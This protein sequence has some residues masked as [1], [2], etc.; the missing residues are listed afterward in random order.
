MTYYIVK[1]EHT[2]LERWEQFLAPHI[3]YLAGL[4]KQEKL[5]MSGPIKNNDE[6]VNEA[7]LVFSVDD[8]DELQSLMENDPYWIEDLI[9]DYTVY[10]WEPLFGQLGAAPEEIEEYFKNQKQ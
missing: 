5:L 6:K 4:I 1:Y 7:M 10:E 3:L 9:S 8:R 2:E